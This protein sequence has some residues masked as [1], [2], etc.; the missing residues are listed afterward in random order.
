MKS[1]WLSKS[2]SLI[3]GEHMKE[4]TVLEVQNLACKKY[5]RKVWVIIRNDADKSLVGEVTA[6]GTPARAK[7]LPVGTTFKS[8]LTI[9]E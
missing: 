7:D 2:L 9:P 4:I 8:I 1:I 6:S 3:K 5:N